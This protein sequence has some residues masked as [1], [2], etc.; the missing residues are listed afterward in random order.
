ML[1]LLL[2][3][4]R[5]WQN[6]MSFVKK[7]VQLF[8]IIYLSVFAGSCGLDIYY[9]LEPVK[10]ANPADNT[11]D[12]L[13]RYFEF[14]TNESVNESSGIFV[15][16]SVYYKIYN[17]LSTLTSEATS[18]TNSNSE[19]TENG[20]NRMISLGYKRMGVST[21]LDP[22][23]ELGD[24][25]LDRGVKIRLYTEGEASGDPYQ[26]TVT[27]GN[28]PLMDGSEY[29]IPLRSDG[30]STFDFFPDNVSQ[31]KNLCKW[32]GI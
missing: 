20:Y 27:V 7:V 21:N 23:I 5:L 10:D 13:V 25:S 2:K 19:Y 4:K 24:I 8:F 9:V 30:V 1:H 26:A 18:I 17:N 14:T 32:K 31:K 29:A 16:T 22:L 6:K 15:G 12:I 28:V 11:R 3:R